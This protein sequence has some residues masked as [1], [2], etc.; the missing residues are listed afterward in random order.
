MDSKI[1]DLLN[2]KY[3]F[4]L[5]D[6]NNEKFEK[7]FEEGQTKTY[8]NREFLPRAFFVERAIKGKTNQEQID[9]MFSQ[10]L[11]KVAIVDGL[12]YQQKLSIGKAEIKKYS[13]NEIIIETKNTGNGFLVLSDAN[14]PTWEAFIDG[15]KVEVFKTDY[16][17]RGILVPKGAHEIV[18]KNRLF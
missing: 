13:E 15:K 8:K 3:V 14:Y 1:I 17:L 4:S 6:I 5:S 2:V 18:F 10:D 16:A 12:D 11:S 9:E 7:V